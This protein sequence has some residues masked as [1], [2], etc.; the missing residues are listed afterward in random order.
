MGDGLRFAL[1]R[2]LLSEGSF[3]LLVALL[4]SEKLLFLSFANFAIFGVQLS[5]EGGERV[6]I[7]GSASAE[8]RQLLFEL[9]SAV[10]DD[11]GDIGRSR[12]LL[13]HT[14]N[15]RG[16]VL[17]SELVLGMGRSEE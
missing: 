8:L 9:L 7:T 10:N 5:L 16:G 6:N 12:V 3:G 14:L 11:F 2:V 4:E 17:A 13:G 1:L 15:E